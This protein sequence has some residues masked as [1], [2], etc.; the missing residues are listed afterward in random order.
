MI[1]DCSK[2]QIEELMKRLCGCIIGHYFWYIMMTNVSMPIVKINEN[3]TQKQPSTVYS[4]EDQVMFEY[5]GST[6]SEAEMLRGS[7][8]YD[9]EV[10]L[11]SRVKG[12]VAFIQFQKLMQTL[13]ASDMKYRMPDFPQF[14]LVRQLAIS[15]SDLLLDVE[16][17]FDPE[18]R[19]EDP[20][21]ELTSW[22]NMSIW[23]I[24]NCD[25]HIRINSS[26]SQWINNF[27]DEIT[28]ISDDL[29][30]Q[31]AIKGFM[32]RSDF[33]P[34]YITCFSFG[35][36]AALSISSSADNPITSDQ[37]HEGYDERI[38]SVTSN[39][40]VNAET[41]SAAS[42]GQMIPHA[43]Q[44]A[45]LNSDEINRKRT[46]YQMVT[47]TQ[48]IE[49][50]L[51]QFKDMFFELPSYCIIKG[52]DKAIFQTA[53]QSLIETMKS[54]DDLEMHAEYYDTIFYNEDYMYLEHWLIHPKTGMLTVFSTKPLMEKPN[55]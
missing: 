36:G 20:H 44:I 18:N 46:L 7:W 30:S 55:S 48:S 54:S 9:M 15:G 3:I 32:Q 5:R 13:V 41:S 2:I 10:R 29:Q 43:M 37:W 26:T 21:A 14:I 22:T 42:W 53:L 35:N 45:A 40:L 34:N 6:I 16:A 4:E 1:S 47:N 31:I 52:D 33:D 27:L 38:T 17:D 25:Y 50:A 12:E 11:N 23:D 24:D 39:L 19:C 28:N 49:E 51:T 8:S